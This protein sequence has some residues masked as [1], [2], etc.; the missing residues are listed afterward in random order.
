MKRK[1]EMR[2][3]ILHITVEPL[4]SVRGRDGGCDRLE[5]RQIIEYSSTQTYIAGNLL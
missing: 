4:F 1:Y 2:Y 3:A 5:N